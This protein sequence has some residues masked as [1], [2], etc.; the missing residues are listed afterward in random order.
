[1]EQNYLKNFSWIQIFRKMGCIGDS[2]SSGEFEY[3]LNGEK[4]YWD[5]YEY[6]WGKYIERTTGVQV[7]NFSH[8]G[9]TAKQLYQSAEQKANQVK[10]INM[11]FE[12]EYLMQAYFV[13]L[14][15]NDIKGGSL[16]ELYIDGVG[17]AKED[18]C[19]QDYRKNKDSFA[20]WYAKIIQHIQELQPDTK[21]FLLTMPKE[22]TDHGEEEFAKLIW[23]IAGQLPNCYVIDLYGQGP[24]YDAAFKRKY[25]NGHMNAMGYLLT[26][27]LVVEYVDKIIMEYPLEFKYVQFIGSGLQPYRQRRR[28]PLMG[29]ASWN[30]YRTNISEEKMKKQAD[31]LVATGLA[32]CGYTYLNMDDGF[33]GGREENGR[34]KFHAERFPNGIKPVADYAH[35]LGLQAGIYS[36]AGDNTCGYYYDAE[37]ESGAGTGLYGHEEQDLSLFFEEYGFDFIKVDWC[38]A[39]RLGLDERTQYIKIG[40]IIEKLRRK[41]NKPIVYNICRWQFPGDW[42]VE[43]ADSW[44]TGADITPDFESVLRQ[45]DRIRPLRKFC[46][47]GHVNDLDMMQ[48]GNGLSPEEEKAHFVMW[49]MMSAPLVLGCDLT[50][51]NPDTLELLKNRELIALNQDSACLQAYVLDSIYDENGTELGQVWIKNLGKK[52]SAEKAVAFLNRSTRILK[53]KLELQ[54]AG[55]CGCILNIRDLLKSEDVQAFQ[56]GS[57]GA[58]IEISV[59]PHSVQVYRIK[60]EKSVP[61]TVNEPEWEEKPMEIISA[62]KCRELLKAGAILVDVRTNREYAEEHLNG[63]VNIPYTEIHASAPDILSDKNRPVIVYCATG[64]RSAQAKYS[65]D[66]LGY[67]SVYDLGRKEKMEKD[68]KRRTGRAGEG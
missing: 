36:E 9:L 52:D 68:C 5:C 37:G 54:K 40:E 43:I 23:E 27:Q 58:C 17:N 7:V 30:C 62:E 66:C 3:D 12:K 48:I 4:G 1:M 14:G 20:G 33:F 60:S 67:E 39:L 26:A 31:A 57:E 29:W 46:G 22:E 8:G 15:V 11:L 13:A 2:L 25:F 50:K 41:L 49:C 32:D 45:I 6:S 35:K 16:D 64:K 63:A 56:K 10:A 44:R 59:L 38:G 51:L 19:I 53:M 42:A 28:A 47:P 61:V 55:L 24:E 21:F 65:L 18:I 34:L